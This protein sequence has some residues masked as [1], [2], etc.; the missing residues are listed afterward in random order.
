MIEDKALVAQA[1]NGNMEAFRTLVER[2]KQ[3]IYYLALDLS[4]NHFDAEDLSQEVFIRALR[5][6]GKFRGDAKFSSWLYRITV[7]CHIDSKRKKQVST[8][9]I[10]NEEASRDIQ[11]IKAPDSQ[12]T[13]PDK[14]VEAAGIQ[15]HIQN[16]LNLLSARERSVFVLRH[17]QEMPLKE[18]GA[19]LDIA[20]GTVKAL[21]FRAIRRLQKEL[22][23]Y[24]A[25]I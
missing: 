23:F 19:V 10:N 9:S 18:I 15:T 7:N 4:G 3:M 25:D 20:E 22:A 13:S 21:L 14:Q 17:Y 24:Q 6:I 2:Y 16:A 5:F 12:K 11:E 8:V 1:Q